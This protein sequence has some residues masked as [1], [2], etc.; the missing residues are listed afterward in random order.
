[1]A[2]LTVYMK[3][4]AQDSGKRHEHNGVRLTVHDH[5]LR[6]AYIKSDIVVNYPFTSIEKWEA[7]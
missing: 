4:D 6:V 2:D 1:M 5:Y 7:R 3:K